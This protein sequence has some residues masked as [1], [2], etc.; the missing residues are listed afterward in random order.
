MASAAAPDGSMAG[1]RG[2]IAWSEALVEG[3]RRRATA[4]GRRSMHA[5]GVGV[6][7]WMGCAATRRDVVTLDDLHARR[8]TR[9]RRLSTILCTAREGGQSVCMTI[10]ASVA[11]CRGTG[12]SVSSLW[13]VEP[14]CAWCYCA[15]V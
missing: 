7:A 6:H 12:D 5:V 1:Q 3:S 11:A 9:R 8:R 4:D 10:K 13:T 14:W 2:A 15:T